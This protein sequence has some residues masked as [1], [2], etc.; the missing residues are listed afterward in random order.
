MFD[1]SSTNGY[2][3]YT[4]IQ[5]SKVDVNDLPIVSVSIA[6]LSTA[7]AAE[8]CPICQSNSGFIRIYAKNVPNGPITLGYFIIQG[9]AASW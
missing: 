1:S 5:N 6:S 3:Y 2:P 9:Q 8:L 7:T 4:D